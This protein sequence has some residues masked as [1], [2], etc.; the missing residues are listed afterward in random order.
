MQALHTKTQNRRA[1]DSSAGKSSRSPR[2]GIDI[3]PVVP[4]IGMWNRRMA[5]DHEFAMVLQGV[6]KFLTRS[7][8]RSWKFCCGIGTPGRMPACTNR[9]IAYTAAKA[10]AETLQEN[11]RARAE[12]RAKATPMRIYFSVDSRAQTDAVGM[13]GSAYRPIA[14]SDEGWLDLAGSPPSG[15]R[16]YRAGIPHDYSPAGPTANR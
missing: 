15:P 8:S 7:V 3:D 11:L 14:A 1:F 5:V 16:D 6:E 13:R 9:E 12:K 10:V 2:A 4:D